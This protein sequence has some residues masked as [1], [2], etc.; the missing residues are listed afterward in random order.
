MGDHPKR[1]VLNAPRVGFDTSKVDPNLLG[2]VRAI[3]RGLLATYAEMACDAAPAIGDAAGPIW[4]SGS[5]F[6]NANG[7]FNI[8]AIMPIYSK[9]YR[10]LAAFFDVPRFLRDSIL[11]DM[12]RGDVPSWW[13]YDTTVS[14]C[15]MVSEVPPIVMRA[16]VAAL[17][18][19][20]PVVQDGLRFAI[21]QRA[22]AQFEM[23]TREVVNALVQPVVGDDE[24]LRLWTFIPLVPSP[25]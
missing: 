5:G 12:V 7:F 23:D 11:T 16:W 25:P 4:S 3:S 2:E 1:K 10:N 18:K 21:S 20:D 9:P 15:R 19:G 6:T 17:A 22:M 24:L 8:K 13:L 14:W